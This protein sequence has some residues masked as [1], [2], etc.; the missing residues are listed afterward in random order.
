M[1]LARVTGIESVDWGS[2]RKMIGLPS[3]QYHTILVLGYSRP[4]HWKKP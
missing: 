3:Y 4:M 2:Q 1:L